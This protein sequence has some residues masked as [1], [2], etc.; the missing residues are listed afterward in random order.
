MDNCCVLFSEA[1]PWGEPRGTQ[2]TGTLVLDT[3]VRSYSIL[4]FT[5]QWNEGPRTGL[6]SLTEQTQWLIRSL[7]PPSGKT[8]KCL[9]FELKLNLQSSR[10][11]P[12]GARTWWFI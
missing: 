5:W 6:P 1:F 8:L 3:I 11:L 9:I 4:M 7:Q 2:E 10:L 12:G